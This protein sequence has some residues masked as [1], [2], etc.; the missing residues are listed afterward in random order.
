MNQ[1]KIHPYC[2]VNEPNKEA[3]GFLSQPKLELPKPPYVI[4]L[5]QGERLYRRLE[6]NPSVKK[7]GGI[8]SMMKTYEHTYVNLVYER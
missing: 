6:K 3:M 7:K 1:I 8:V 5:T 2:S 4:E